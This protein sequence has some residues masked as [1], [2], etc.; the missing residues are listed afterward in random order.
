[1]MGH[2]VGQTAMGACCQAAL[3][4]TATCY[5]D[6]YPTVDKVCRCSSEDCCHACLL[7]CQMC[8]GGG[9]QDLQDYAPIDMMP[10]SENLPACGR[11]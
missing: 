6:L 4:L 1:M 8:W 2:A 3:R 7:R 9:E 11:L 10:T 5:S